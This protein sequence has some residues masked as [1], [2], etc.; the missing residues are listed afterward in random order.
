M[1][2]Y[3][4]GNQFSYCHHLIAMMSDFAKVASPPP[5]RLLLLQSSLSGWKE[6]RVV[7]VSERVGEASC[8]DFIN[9]A[10]Y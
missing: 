3:A 4:F 1:H 6:S 2:P 5:L 8:G 7:F 10:S 9:E